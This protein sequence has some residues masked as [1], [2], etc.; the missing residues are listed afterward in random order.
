[1]TSNV[2]NVRLPVF[3][4]YEIPGRLKVD[5]LG[6]LSGKLENVRSATLRNEDKAFAEITISPD[7]M[8]GFTQSAYLSPGELIAALAFELAKVLWFCSFICLVGSILFS[9]SGGFVS[10][11]EPLKFYVRVG[12]CAGLVVAMVGLSFHLVPMLKDVWVIVE[13]MLGRRI[14]GCTTI[15][16][17]AVNYVAAIGDKGI[18]FSVSSSPDSKQFV[19]WHEIDRVELT[20]RGSWQTLVLRDQNDRQ[21]GVMLSPYA[22][23]LKI[24]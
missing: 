19:A 11:E 4:L 23:D 24:E 13:V 8:K 12:F 16:T 3:D 5:L 18:Y 6:S 21:L 14:P 10:T 9:V 2:S 1:M 7:A 22:G 20:P 17:G 15:L